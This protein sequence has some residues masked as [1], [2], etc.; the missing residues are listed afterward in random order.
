MDLRHELACLGVPDHVLAQVIWADLEDRD[1]TPKEL[2]D[3]ARRLLP[4]SACE[5]VADRLG[6][7][8]THGPRERVHTELNAQIFPRRVA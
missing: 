2:L 8:G 7:R 4:A 6:V 3:L 5:I 1:R